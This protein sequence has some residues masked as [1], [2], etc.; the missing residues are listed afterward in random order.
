MMR[1]L[2]EAEGRVLVETGG[3][4]FWAGRREVLERRGGGLAKLVANGFDQSV[5]VE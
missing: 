3:E 5:S 4:G 1:S 2:S